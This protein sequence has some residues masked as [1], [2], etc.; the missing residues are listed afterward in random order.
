M[1]V[2]KD[3]M[4]LAQKVNYE[5]LGHA[6]LVI[7]DLERLGIL[8]HE[9]VVERPRSRPTL[10]AEYFLTEYGVSFV[11]AVTIKAETAPRTGEGEEKS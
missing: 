7:H 4:P 9:P 5:R 11:R 6:E 2:F 1:E 8:T 10:S 3:R